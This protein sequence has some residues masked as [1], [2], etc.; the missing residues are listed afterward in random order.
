MPEQ[1]DTTG[2]L[3]KVE[4][5]NKLRGSTYGRLASGIPGMSADIMGGMSV[6]QAMAAHFP[7]QQ[8]Q[9]GDY[10]KTK[11]DLLGKLSELQAADAERVEG[12]LPDMG[13][14][15]ELLKITAEL[16]GKYMGNIQKSAEAQQKAINQAVATASEGANDRL[17]SLHGDVGDPETA[18]A[19]RKHAVRLSGSLASTD[20]NIASAALQDLKD[21]IISM[22][23]DPSS[24]IMLTRQLNNAIIQNSQTIPGGEFRDLRSVLMGP[25]AGGAADPSAQKILS[26]IDGKLEGVSAEVQKVL[27]E[28]DARQAAMVVAAYNSGGAL[29]PA[30]P[31]AFQAVWDVVSGIRDG[32]LDADAA[33]QQ[34]VKDLTGEDVGMDPSAEMEA[35]LEQFSKPS[36]PPNLAEA[37]Q[38]LL[39]SSEFQA[40]MKE[41]GYEPGQEVHALRNA[42]TD[43]RD[44]KM[45]DRIQG[46]KTRAENERGLPSPSDSAR[47]AG[48]SGSAERPEMTLAEVQ[49]NPD[50]YQVAMGE[51]PET[52]EYELVIKDRTTGA[53][54][55][56]DPV[57]LSE[58]QMETFREVAEYADETA[59]G[60]TTYRNIRA[61]IDVPGGAFDDEYINSIL[62]PK[63]AEKEKKGPKI[64]SIPELRAA[65]TNILLQRAQGLPSTARKIERELR[66][67]PE[68]KALRDAKKAAVSTNWQPIDK[69]D[70]GKAILPEAEF[71]A[72]ES[73]PDVVEPLTPEQQAESDSAHFQSA[74][75][76]GMPKK[77][78]RQALKDREKERK[79]AIKKY[80][81][82]IGA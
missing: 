40:Y 8:A 75:D 72:R 2:A 29:S 63:A 58:K 3:S 46:A 51:N 28:E 82:E 68:K 6:A 15:L 76:A 49:A 59:E 67:D 62:G 48:G 33:M 9:G 31:K 73:D 61:E 11:A 1:T 10:Y 14:T 71:E 56:I 5:L 47:L 32:R 74:F 17:E 60:A 43:L 18:S 7:Q 78:K 16:T 55:A 35:L 65:T 50:Q 53:V 34:L 23:T 36:V 81:L 77:A 70:K 45:T 42:R 44:K 12:M 26:I 27:G 66:V 38:A 21:T 4:E 30:D 52:G 69:D 24:Q 22:A 37:R 41:K 39:S 25:A 54:K 80:L 20:H 79:A 13:D 57:T 19:V 64:P